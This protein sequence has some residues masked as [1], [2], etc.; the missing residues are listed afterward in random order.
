MSSR[1]K[2]N[3]THAPVH[4]LSHKQHT[5]KK[6]TVMPTI[7][8]NAVI[9][10]ID[11]SI[12]NALRLRNIHVPK[13]AS[14]DHIYDTSLSCENGK[15]VSL[16]YNQGYYNQGICRDIFAQVCRQYENKTYV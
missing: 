9:H 8:K 10:I 12:I 5:K 16:Y 6:S 13:F 3:V 1:L 15:T 2:A 7:N 11:K 4:S 14:L